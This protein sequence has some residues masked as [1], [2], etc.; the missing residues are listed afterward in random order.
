MESL[1]TSRRKVVGGSRASLPKTGTKLNTRK[2][3]TQAG[4]ITVELTPT[5]KIIRQLHRWYPKAKIIGWKYEVNG[6][7]ETAVAVARDQIKRCRTNACVANGP[8]YG[9]GFGLVSADS[10]THSPNAT[11]LLKQLVKFTR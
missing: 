11:A 1:H 3:P 6:D 2:I 7:R 8:G 5:P 9:E 10:V 4:P